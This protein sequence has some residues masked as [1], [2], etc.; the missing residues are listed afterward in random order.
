[1]TPEGD[2]SGVLLERNPA[3]VDLERHAERNGMHGGPSE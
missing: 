3:G 2:L 1:M